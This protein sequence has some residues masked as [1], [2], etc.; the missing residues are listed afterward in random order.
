LGKG[1]LVFPI[2]PNTK[3]VP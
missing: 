1:F 3:P 2:Q